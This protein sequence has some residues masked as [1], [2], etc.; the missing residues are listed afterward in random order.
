MGWGVGNKTQHTLLDPH[1][2]LGLTAPEQSLLQAG[3]GL[4]IPPTP[5]ALGL[6]PDYL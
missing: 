2:V 3:N 6:E 1:S 5:K 4:E